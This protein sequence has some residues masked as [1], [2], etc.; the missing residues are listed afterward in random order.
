MALD[1]HRLDNG[2]FLFGLDD[3]QCNYLMNIFDTFTQWTGL[4]IDQ[5]GDAIITTENQ[6]TLINIINKYIDATD[7]NK[8][9]NKTSA[10]LEFKGLIIYFRNN[11]IDVKAKGD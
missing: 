9:K 6:Q 4:P 5:Y 10:I 3:T 2:D 7:L 8:D 11:N 1:F